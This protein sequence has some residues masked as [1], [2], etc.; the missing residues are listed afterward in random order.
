MAL[1]F[2][3]DNVVIAA[4]DRQRSHVEQRINEAEAAVIRRLFDLA[5]AGVGQSSIAKQ[6]NAEGLP[7]PRSQQSRPRAWIQSSVH[8]ALFRPRSAVRSSGIAP[9]SAIAGASITSPIAR[10]PNGCAS[11]RRSSA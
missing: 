1:C 3:Y 11:R 5:A 6:L 4:A 9:A 8:E 10:R 2:G 7:A